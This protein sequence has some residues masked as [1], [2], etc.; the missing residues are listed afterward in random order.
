MAGKIS[1][2]S[3]SGRT[4]PDN[5]DRYFFVAVCGRPRLVKRDTPQA[6]VRASQS[7][8]PSAR[9]DNFKGLFTAIDAATLSSIYPATTAVFLQGAAQIRKSAN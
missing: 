2:S 3:R 9:M 8:L 7:L 6:G 5:L 1:P 4:K